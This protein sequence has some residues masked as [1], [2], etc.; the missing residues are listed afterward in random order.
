MLR[1]AVVTLTIFRTIKA[2][3][4]I[5]LLKLLSSGKIKKTYINEAEEKNNTLTLFYVDFILSMSLTLK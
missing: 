2:T 5:S 4:N 1:I 3:V